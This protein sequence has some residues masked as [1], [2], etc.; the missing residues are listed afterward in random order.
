VPRPKPLEPIKP[1]YIRMSDRH[2]LIL[3]QLG[4]PEWLRKML[5]KHA[6]MPKQYYQTLKETSCKIQTKHK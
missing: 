5:D 4:G 2:W 1:R 3:K 6:P